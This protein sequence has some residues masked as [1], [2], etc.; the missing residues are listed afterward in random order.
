[1]KTLASDLYEPEE[2][3]FEEYGY[4]DYEEEDYIEGDLSEVAKVNYDIFSH[5]LTSKTITVEFNYR[6]IT[7]LQ[8]VIDELSNYIEDNQLDFAS[9]LSMHTETSENG[10]SLLIISFTE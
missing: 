1:M 6:E 2:Y 5:K 9:V 3:E 8:Y 10:N 7:P 4:N